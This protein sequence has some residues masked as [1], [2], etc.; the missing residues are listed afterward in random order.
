MS[1]I[2]NE[3]RNCK[4]CKGEGTTTSQGF[5]TE[6]GKVYP[7]TT[8]TCS[9]CKGAKTF[10]APD[11]KALLML[12]TTGRGMPE[13]KRK[14]RTAPDKKWDQYNSA[15]GARAY[16]VW[17]IARFHGGKDVT[18]PM[19]ASMVISGDPFQDELEALASFIAKK[20][21][22]TDLAG[23]SRWGVLLGTVK[24]ADVPN[25]LPASAYEGGPEKM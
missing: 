12:V 1:E 8:S 9:R 21:F 23:A 16:Y 4:R 25:N 10:T 24:E 15:E 17:R 6:S 22:G 3:V 14:V 5:T 2:N 13:G 19:T 18:M 20:G 7:T 11:M